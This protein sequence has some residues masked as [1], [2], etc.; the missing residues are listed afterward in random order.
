MRLSLKV[1]ESN[2]GHAAEGDPVP[3]QSSECPLWVTSGSRS[4]FPI[5]PLSP[6]QQTSLDAVGTSAKCQKRTF[7]TTVHVSV[8]MSTAVRRPA[9]PRCLTIEL[10]RIRFAGG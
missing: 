2:H 6:K 10:V 7:G 1:S 5:L 9:T 4:A 8:G 3:A